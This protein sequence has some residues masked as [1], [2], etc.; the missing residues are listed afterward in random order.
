MPLSSAP[1]PPLLL[2]WCLPTG[3]GSV[4]WDRGLAKMSEKCQ[5]SP[6]AQPE[7]AP[8]CLYFPAYVAF[9]ALTGTLTTSLELEAVRD[10]TSC[11]SGPSK[12]GP[13]SAVLPV[14]CELVISSGHTRGISDPVVTWSE[15]RGQERKAPRTCAPH[16][17]VLEWS[18]GLHQRAG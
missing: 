7:V 15:A 18:S 13:L 16:S 3:P 17:A 8:V 6:A 9:S 2:W 11:G 12:F 1:S 4:P 5:K 14:S 10:L